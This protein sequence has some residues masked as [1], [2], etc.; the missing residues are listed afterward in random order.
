M[1]ISAGGRST[2]L[3][4]ALAL[5]TL[6]ALAA[7]GGFLTARTESDPFMGTICGETSGSEA[8]SNQVRGPHHED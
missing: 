8:G 4:V 3:G 7:G 2:L 6:S 5:V 1:T